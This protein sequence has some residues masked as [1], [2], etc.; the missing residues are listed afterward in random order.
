MDLVL[1]S[2]SQIL[3]N[4]LSIFLLLHHPHRVF[5]KSKHK[6]HFFLKI[7][8]S[9]WIFGVIFICYTCIFSPAVSRS[10]QSGAVHDPLPQERLNAFGILKIEEQS[11]HSVAA[12][13]LDARAM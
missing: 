6:S 12:M 13:D 7:L 5:T 11:I 9:N 8:F 4:I 2:L 1:F 3:L 10:V